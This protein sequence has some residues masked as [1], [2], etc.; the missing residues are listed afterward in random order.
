MFSFLNVSRPASSIPKQVELVAN[1]AI[2]II[3]ILLGFVLVKRFILPQSSKPAVEERAQIAPGTKL[4][5]PGVDWSKG[6]KTLLMVLSTNCH[7]CTESAPFYQRLAQQKAGHG[8]VRMV[9]ALPQSTGEAQKY[10]NDHAISVDE[11]TQSVP[12]AVFARATPTLILLD[13]AGSVL[14]SWVGK[15]SPEKEAE[16]SGRFFGAPRR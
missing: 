5:L 12:G 13:R 11:V 10:L 15:L 7:F 16:V 8:D 14:E 3:A 1:I 9:A 6:D 2:V 4:S